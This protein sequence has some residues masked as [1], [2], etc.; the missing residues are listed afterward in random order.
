MPKKGKKHG[1]II[2]S[3]FIASTKP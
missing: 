3:R 1:S 2:L